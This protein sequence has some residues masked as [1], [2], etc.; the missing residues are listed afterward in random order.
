LT[1]PIKLG[2]A[3]DPAEVVK[4]EDFLENFEGVKEGALN[5]NG[6]YD[7]AMYNAVKAFQAKYAKD[8]LIPWG[9][10][11]PT[12]Y[13]YTTTIKEINLIYCKGAKPSPITPTKPVATPIPTI[14]PVPTPTPTACAPYMTKFIKL[15]AA[16]DTAEVLKL[17]SFLKTYEGFANLAQTGVYDITTYNAV[18]TFQAKYAKDILAPWGTITPT[19]YVYTSTIKEINAIYCS[20]N[21]PDYRQLQF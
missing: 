11:T 1:K 15:G 18:R 20:Q 3:N 9:T 12:G 5:E 8:I 14:K 13:V 10:S 19:G 17:Q 16:N 4:L 7:Q 2:A 21:N 6:I